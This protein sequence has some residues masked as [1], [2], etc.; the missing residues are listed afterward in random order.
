MRK[1]IILVSII[2]ISNLLYGNLDSLQFEALLK[3]TDW[4]ERGKKEYNYHLKRNAENNKKGRSKDNWYILG[5]MDDDDLDLDWVSVIGSSTGSGADEAFVSKAGITLYLKSNVIALNENLITINETMTPADKPSRNSEFFVFLLP[6]EFAN[7]STSLPYSF[8]AKALREGSFSSAEFFAAGETPEQRLKKEEIKQFEKV[9]AVLKNGIRQILRGA[10]EEVDLPY[11]AT[12]GSNTLARV[13]YGVLNFNTYTEL[14]L[15]GATSAQKSILSSYPASY[16]ANDELREIIKYKKFNDPPNSIIN[17][18]NLIATAVYEYK[19]YNYPPGYTPINSRIKTPSFSYNPSMFDIVPAEDRIEDATSIAYT[20]LVDSFATALDQ[21]ILSQQAISSYNFPDDIEYNSG[22]RH[23]FGEESFDFVSSDKSRI[24][25]YTLDHKLALLEKETGVRFFVL[26]KDTERILPQVLWSDFNTKVREAST[27]IDGSFPYVLLTIPYCVMTNKAYWPWDVHKHHYFMPALTSSPSTVDSDNLVSPIYFSRM[28]SILAT[29]GN[30]RA[31]TSLI[32][33]AYRTIPKPKRDKLYYLYAGTNKESKMARVD[34]KSIISS[35]LERDELF[36]NNI[37]IFDDPT[38]RAKISSAEYQVRCDCDESSVCFK[39]KEAASDSSAVFYAQMAEDCLVKQDSLEAALIRAKDHPV[40]EALKGSNSDQTFKPRLKEIY[41]HYPLA[42]S[43]L[44]GGTLLDINNNPIDT[45]YAY[46]PLM[47]ALHEY[48]KKLDWNFILDN[49]EENTFEGLFTND[50]LY[51]I[52]YYDSYYAAADATGLLLSPFGLDFIGDG[53]SVV[54]GVTDLVNTNNTE[55]GLFAIVGGT[56]GIVIIAVPSSAVKVGIKE[57]TEMLNIPF[58]VNGPPNANIFKSLDDIADVANAT[59]PRDLSVLLKIKDGNLMDDFGDK[60]INIDGEDI[61]LRQFFIKGKPC[62]GP[63]S[64]LRYERN[65]DELREWLVYNQQELLRNDINIRGPN[66]EFF[67]KPDFDKINTCEKCM[68][69]Q[70]VRNMP[71]VQQRKEFIQLITDYPEVLTKGFLSDGGKSDFIG[72]LYWKRIKA[73]VGGGAIPPSLLNPA[74]LADLYKDLA[75][76][77]DDLF[78]F[79]RNGSSYCQVCIS[80]WKAIRGQLD[81]LPPDKAR[82]LLQELKLPGNAALADAMAANPN[83]VKAWDALDDIGSTFKTDITTLQNLASDYAINNNL[84]TYFKNNADKFL[85]WKSLRDD[86]TN[87]A[88][89]QNLRSNEKFIDLFHNVINNPRKASPPNSSTMW[90]HMLGEPS[91]LGLGGFHH[92]DGASKDVATGL[93][94]KITPEPHPSSPKYLQDGSPINE[95]PPPSSIPDN[96]NSSKIT[97]DNDTGYSP[98]PVDN[99]PYETLLYGIKNYTASDGSVVPGW[100]PFTKS[101]WPANW[102]KE[103]TIAFISKARHE[104]NASHLV[105]G[106]PNTYRKTVQDE[107][108]LSMVVEMYINGPLD[109]VNF[110]NK[111]PSAFPKP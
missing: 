18:C 55:R 76:Y 79:I 21:G 57:G 14:F 39:N 30:N 9:L 99:E 22:L 43:G 90:E 100:K 12:S 44:T 83:M 11:S 23:I 1:Q 84:L 101:M 50:V 27:Q 48:E 40:F 107:N 4:I 66:F 19:L 52:D 51:K 106:T 10:H 47:Y 58:S 36:I 71:D 69:V 29:P 103:E 34:V 93:P 111:I 53:L 5:L 25:L 91:G 102:S 72:F 61:P 49:I 97:L 35:T 105:P 74:E 89:S 78:K 65:I 88:I 63:G 38:N 109:N 110:S 60:L 26:L 2:F 94:I 8:K 82:K 87:V 77:D 17:R 7:I 13:I 104:M 24:E 73:A 54:I 70:L 64:G 92:L 45:S 31:F 42:A 85:S 86:L 46:I 67:Y 16:I 80:R 75:R 96:P 33:E 37:S 98:N 6:Q 3:N 41:L 15:G 56:V 68:L 95:I 28:D 20:N 62:T 32:K 81:Q 59:A 108:G